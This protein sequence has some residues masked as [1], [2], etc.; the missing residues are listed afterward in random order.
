LVGAESA[1]AVADLQL[2]VELAVLVV[3]EARSRRRRIPE[4]AIAVEVPGVSQRVAVRIRGDLQGFSSAWGSRWGS[5]TPRRA[6]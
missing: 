6:D 5:A 1:S 4:G 2:H 3:G